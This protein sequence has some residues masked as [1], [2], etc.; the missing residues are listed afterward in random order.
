[1]PCHSISSHCHRG[2]IGVAA[3]AL[4]AGCAAIP[5]R[6]HASQSYRAPSIVLAYP[7]LGAVLPT[8]RAF[9]AL[10]FAQ[11]EADDPIDVA[12]FKATVDGID[13]TARFRL[14]DTQAWAR[15][16]DSV[17]TPGTGGQPGLAPG[18]HTLSARICSARGA[19]GALT[20]VIDVRPWDRALARPR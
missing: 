3:L 4:S 9:V 20:A 1:M 8:D 18:A 15:L 17:A 6:G 5:V 7:E 13:H 10:R 19:C 2:V 16:D 11:G 14:T 12:S